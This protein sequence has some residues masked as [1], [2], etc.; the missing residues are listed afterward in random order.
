[1]PQVVLDEALAEPDVEDEKEGEN[2]C[3]EADIVRNKQE[4]I[5]TVHD[6][7]SLLQG[8]D[9]YMNRSQKKQKIF[10]WGYARGAARLRHKAPQ[11]YRSAIVIF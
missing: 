10:L 3:V 2:G 9:G 11:A 7:L 6:S 8:G 5:D 4:L 1:M